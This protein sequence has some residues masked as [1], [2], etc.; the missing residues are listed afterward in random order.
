MGKKISLIM[1][2][3]AFIAFGCQK[4]QPTDEVISQTYIHKYGYAVS[5]EEWQAKNYPGQIVSSL[6]NGITVTATYEDGQLQGPCTFT[7]PHSHTV[8]KYVLYHQNNP[9]KEILYDI[10]G[11]PVQETVRLAQNRYCITMWYKDGVPKSIEEYAQEKILEGQYFTPDNELEARIEK[12]LGTRVVRDNLGVLICKDSVEDGLLT[13]R[14]SFYAGGSPESLAHYFLN[15]LHG[16]KRTFTSEGEP[17]AIEEWSNGQLHG[18]SS[19]YKNGMK[20]VEISYLYGKKT[21]LETHFLDGK[22]ISHQI[23]WENGIKHGPETFFLAE[24]QKVIW[25]YDGKEVSQTRFQ[26]LSQIDAMISES[27]L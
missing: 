21:G 26:E 5:K 12:G 6:R 18:I 9:I 19:Y 10:A 2:T 1:V 13:K 4:D 3:L 22:T 16:Q 7:Y 25:N 17:L 8:E 27:S 14:E 24:G 11:M 15:Q 20:E 23:S